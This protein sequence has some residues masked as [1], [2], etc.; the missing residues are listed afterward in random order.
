MLI[1]ALLLLFLLFPQWL[2][3]RRIRHGYRK[4]TPPVPGR[5]NTAKPPWVR[6]EVLYLKAL[7]PHASCR[8]IANTFGRLFALERKMTVGRT[9]VHEV[10]RKYEHEIVL[11]RRRIKNARPRWV[12]K[13]FVWAMDLTGKTDTFGCLHSILGLIDHGTRAELGLVAL[14]NKASFTLLGHLFLAIG[15][16]GMPRAIRTDIEAVFTSRLFRS[17][18]FLLGIRH[19]RI[20]LHC[21]WQNGRVERFFGTLKLSLDQLA[22][23]SLEALNHALVEFRFYYNHV[24]PHQNLDGATPPKCGGASIRMPA[25]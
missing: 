17:A 10:L 11:L 8:T 14:V 22:V 24:R 13:N 2:A 5:R 16:S 6:Y 21:P 23:D 7:M 18:L 4:Q 1:A 19:Q 3:R 15:R 25:G 20:D 9:F 12:P